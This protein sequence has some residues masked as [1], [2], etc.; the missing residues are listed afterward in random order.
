MGA[1]PD[2]S[3]VLPETETITIFPHPWF[4]NRVQR[5]HTLETIQRNSGGLFHTQ[6]KTF[7]KIHIFIHILADR[8][9]RSTAL[10]PNGRLKGHLSE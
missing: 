8:L 9:Q 3:K 4:R 10:K 1:R 2:T 5:C 6:R 7:V